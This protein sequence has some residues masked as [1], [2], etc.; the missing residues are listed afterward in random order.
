YKRIHL[1]I[2]RSEKHPSAEADNAPRDV[3]A[4]KREGK[5]HDIGQRAAE[6][7]L[8]AEDDKYPARTRKTLGG[9]SHEA[10]VPAHIGAGE[11]LFAPAKHDGSER[12]GVQHI[13]EHPFAQVAII[14]TVEQDF[15]WGIAVRVDD[16]ES[17]T[18]GKKC[19]KQRR[20]P[21]LRGDNSIVH[22]V[23]P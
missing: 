5:R 16:R 10:V 15:A 1:V 20:R 18:R 7:L 12:R 17:K 4:K 22:I 13:I 11:K 8:V 9:T 3:E 2:R 23:L 19:M 14:L 21:D 6:V